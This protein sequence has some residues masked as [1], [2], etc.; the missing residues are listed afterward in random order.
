MRNSRRGLHGIPTSFLPSCSL[1]APGRCAAHISLQE[2]LWW[3]A[4]DLTV[5]CWIHHRIPRSSG[6][7][8]ELFPTKHSSNRR[9]PP[10]WPKARRLMDNFCSVT[11][12]S[13]TKPFSVCCSLRLF[14]QSFLYIPL[15]ASDLHCCLKYIFLLYSWLLSTSSLTC[16]FLDKSLLDFCLSRNLNQLIIQGNSI[17]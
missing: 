12:I 14:L 2:S 13:L 9:A 11:L 7:F 5:S 4:V 17:Q 10:F 1:R 3:G 6:L 16:I 8:L 15:Q